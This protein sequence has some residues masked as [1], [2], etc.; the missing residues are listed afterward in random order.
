[1]QDYLQ[2]TQRHKQ[3]IHAALQEGQAELEL[4]AGIFNAGQALA[5]VAVYIMERGLVAGVGLTIQTLADTEVS[6]RAHISAFVV[7]YIMGRGLVAAVGFT[8]QTLADT[9]LSEHAHI[10]ASGAVYIMA[11]GLEATGVGFTVHAQAVTEFTIPTTSDPL[12]TAT[13]T[14]IRTTTSACLITDI[15]TLIRVITTRNL[16]QGMTMVT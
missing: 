6:Q 7:V 12:I 3:G 15:T 13:T 9:E 8:I 16:I 1:L 11:R 2:V 10:S 14:A 4:R 5:S